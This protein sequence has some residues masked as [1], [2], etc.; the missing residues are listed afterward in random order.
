M[1]VTEFQQAQI[2]AL[3]KKVEELESENKSL[4]QKK[5]NESTKRELGKE[6]PAKA[7]I[8]SIR[9]ENQQ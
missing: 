4:K 8:K 9:F 5:S 2:E 1:S 7:G 3:Q 6:S